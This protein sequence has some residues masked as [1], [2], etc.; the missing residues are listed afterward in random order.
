MRKFK[1]LSHPTNHI[2]YKSIVVVVSKSVS[3][4]PY[5]KQNNNTKYKNRKC[6]LFY[7]IPTIEHQ[8]ENNFQFNLG[9]K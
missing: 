5:S 9:S 3:H 7:K 2:Q 8:K 4:Q 1:F 6:H